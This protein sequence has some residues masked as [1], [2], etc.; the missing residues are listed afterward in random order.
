MNTKI[1]FLAKILA[2]KVSKSSCSRNERKNRFSGKILVE[3]VYL[4][5]SV[6]EMNATV[7]FLA[8]RVF[9]MLSVFSS[10]Q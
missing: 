3:R 10:R 1:D 7:D 4:N 6:E 2:E 9:L 8:E 5:L